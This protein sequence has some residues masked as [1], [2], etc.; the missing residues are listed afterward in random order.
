MKKLFLLV[1]GAML[2]AQPVDAQFFKKLLKKKAKTEKKKK[3]GSKAD[4]IDDEAQTAMADW[5]TAVDNQT[6]RNASTIHRKCLKEQ[7]IDSDVI[8]IDEMSMVGLDVFVMLLNCITNTK[9]KFVLCGDMYQL[10]SISK[11]CVFSDLI[12]SHNVP[13]AELTKVFRYDTSG[14]AYVGENVRLGRNFFDDT[15]RVKIKDNILTIS[16][17]YKFIETEEIFDE[18]I[19]EYARLRRIYKED[20]IK[21]TLVW[22][23]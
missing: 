20:E 16:N 3:S 19:K 18:I 4:G 13:T 6:N 12:E 8:I 5:A 22:V 7:E 9:A 21:P 11:G 1:L 23:R 15:D 2:V 10:P 17:N 14:G